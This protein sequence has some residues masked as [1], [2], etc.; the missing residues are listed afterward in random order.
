[1]STNPTWFIQVVEPFGNHGTDAY[2]ALEDFKRQ[3]GFVGGRL[4]EPDSV[5]PEWRIQAFLQDEPEAA[6]HPN[7]LPDGMRRVVVMDS[8][9][10]GLGI[11]PAGELEDTS[12]PGDAI[13]AEFGQVSDEER[14]VLISR[15]RGCGHELEGI[16]MGVVADD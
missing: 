6:A 8:M 14:A 12:H 1:M 4:L 3:D 5:T 15:A 16:T 10:V 9:R 13:A 2:Q 7:A 11:P